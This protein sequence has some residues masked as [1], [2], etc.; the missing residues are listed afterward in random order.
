MATFGRRTASL[1]EL[2]HGILYSSAQ[3]VG[4]MLGLHC[5][6]H[7]VEVNYDAE[8]GGHDHHDCS[9][10]GSQGAHG[11]DTG[12]WKLKTAM[13]GLDGT[14]KTEV[15]SHLIRFHVTVEVLHQIEQGL[16]AMAQRHATGVD[17]CQQPHDHH[18]HSG[19]AYGRI[20]EEG[21]R[22]TRLRHHGHRN[23]EAKRHVL[24][25]H[26]HDAHAAEAGTPC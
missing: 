11:Y 9:G 19:C 26:E 1:H 22:D 21:F 7:R 12:N 4:R 3:R 10:E 6:R 25:R 24:N 23:Q 14:D 16:L 13:D 20:H 2:A 18:D 8:E 5:R 15:G 17:L